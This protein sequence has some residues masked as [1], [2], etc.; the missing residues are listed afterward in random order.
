MIKL[1]DQSE[2]G[3]RTVA[4][5]E[6]NPIASDSGDEKRIYKA[7]AR[8]SRKSRVDRGG[9]RGRWRG[10][11]YRRTY[12]RAIESSQCD[13]NQRQT[14]Q[15]K[16]PGLCFSCS[17]PEH[18]KFVNHSAVYILFWSFEISDNILRNRK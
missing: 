8:A 3:W 17:M 5:Y 10:H 13:N 18:W 15:T 12:R 11:P 2:R 1:A 7:E 14:Q 16:R 9:R 6:T 4:E